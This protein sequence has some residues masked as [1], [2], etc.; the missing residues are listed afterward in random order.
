MQTSASGYLIARDTQRCLH[1]NFVDKGEP[2]VRGFSFNFPYR[3]FPHASSLAA[4]VVA[5]NETM[6]EAADGVRC[7]TL[8]TNCDA[9]VE[10]SLP[11]RLLAADNIS[12]GVTIYAYR[13]SNLT[14]LQYDVEFS[15]FLQ[16]QIAIAPAHVKHVEATRARL[17]G[18]APTVIGVH[19][20]H[21]DNCED[22]TKVK[23]MRTCP[24][25]DRFAIAMRREMTKDPKVGAHGGG[26]LV[27]GR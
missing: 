27:M 8:E 3:E 17:F 13:P 16:N 5:I 7:P 22:G 26:G 14:T 4:D 10:A 20:R 24:S 12:I 2:Q 21:G 23:L 15:K 6:F 11:T 25:V 1:F 9:Y 19:F 18:A